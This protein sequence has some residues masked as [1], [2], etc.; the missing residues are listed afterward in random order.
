LREAK[1]F[2]P[3]RFMWVGRETR[4]IER[5][6]RSDYLSFVRGSK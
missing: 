1:G 5:A 4:V 6:R 3:G 2:T